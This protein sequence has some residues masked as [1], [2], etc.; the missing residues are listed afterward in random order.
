MKDIELMEKRIEP[1]PWQY[2]NVTNIM[3][4][5]VPWQRLSYL[6]TFSSQFQIISCKQQEVSNAQTQADESLYQ[7]LRTSTAIR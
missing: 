7:S 4:V 2:M 3:S 1:M 6:W 5:S